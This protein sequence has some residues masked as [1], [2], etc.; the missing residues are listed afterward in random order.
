MQKVLFTACFNYGGTTIVFEEET[1]IPCVPFFGLR[2]ISIGDK[3][4]LVLANNDHISTDIAWHDDNVRFEVEVREHWKFPVTDDVVDYLFVR[5]QHWKR[6][7]TTD[8]DTLK[9]KMLDDHNRHS[10][11]I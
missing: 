11:K 10:K 8:I 9:R 1:H 3:E 5:F 6:I 7:D 4:G 2:Y